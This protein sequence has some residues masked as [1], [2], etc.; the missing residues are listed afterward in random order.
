MQFAFSYF[1][2]L[3]S[4]KVLI[5][6]SEIFDKFDTDETGLV[7]NGEI[8]IMFLF[9]YFKDNRNY[10][11]FSTW[12]DREIRTLATQL[13]SIPLTR[14]SILH[15]EG[16]L[17]RCAKGHPVQPVPPYERY[18]DSKLVILY[19]SVK[20]FIYIFNSLRYLKPFT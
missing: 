10:F 15:F 19:Y 12:S 13:Y 11:D 17:Q 9:L 3:I 1:Y 2:F 14:G 6:P 7:L 8:N 4:E 5:S 18:L 20:L 16:L